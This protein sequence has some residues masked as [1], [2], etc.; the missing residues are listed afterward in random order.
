MIFNDLH[1]F[2]AHRARMWEVSLSKREPMMVGETAGLK[3][4]ACLR[5]FIGPA[6][7]RLLKK[8][9]LEN[10][11]CRTIPQRLKAAI[12]LSDLAARTNPCPFK[13]A[14]NR[15]FFSKL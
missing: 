6:R 2:G 9:I 15:E 7:T 1:R 14:L 13:T 12:I 8:W 10:R 11:D 4:P 3:K 5:A